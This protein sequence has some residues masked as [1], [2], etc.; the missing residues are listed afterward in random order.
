MQQRSTELR[1][2]RRHS[3]AQ[4]AG[5]SPSFRSPIEPSSRHARGISAAAGHIDDS[6][7]A[8]HGFSPMG[9]ELRE[10]KYLNPSSTGATAGATFPRRSR[11][12]D[13]SRHGAPDAARA[14]ADTFGQTG[15]RGGG[16]HHPSLLSATPQVM[17]SGQVAASEPDSAAGEMLRLM[18]WDSATP[19]G[20]RLCHH[21]AAQACFVWIC[22]T[23]SASTTSQAASQQQ[24]DHAPA[25][26]Y[27]S[28]H[29]SDHVASARSRTLSGTRNQMAHAGARAMA[30]AAADMPPPSSFIRDLQR[31]QPSDRGG[32]TAHHRSNHTADAE[33][34]QASAA[35]GGGTTE[36]LGGVSPG[37]F[38]RAMSQLPIE[39]SLAYLV[40]DGTP[41]PGGERTAVCSGCTLP[42]FPGEVKHCAQLRCMHGAL[43][44]SG[45]AIIPPA[46]HKAC[47]PL[48]VLHLARSAACLCTACTQR[49]SA[50]HRAGWRAP[51]R[52]RQRRRLREAALVPLLTTA[53]PELP[54]HRAPAGVHLQH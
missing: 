1:Q 33:H 6:A 40:Q 51:G 50:A 12:G 11:D 4:A 43:A 41:H 21:V 8:L 29:F 53:P 15:S 22:V 28:R 20:R 19:T 44:S 9:V 39:E 30:D 3:T 18:G 17:R 47:T 42:S 37:G 35:S 46:A 7:N 25:H 45:V 23:V 27:A 49:Q 14:L 5:P 13:G 24:S 36:N 16:G 31:R 48:I 34:A 32:A 54:L 52:W 26:V 10:M 2:G 38:M